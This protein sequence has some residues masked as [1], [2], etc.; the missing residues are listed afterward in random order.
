MLTSTPCPVNRSG[1]GTLP[2]QFRNFSPSMHRFGGYQAN[3]TFLID[4]LDLLQQFGA[5]A[6][7]ETH[8]REIQRRQRLVA[9]LMPRKTIRV[10]TDVWELKLTEAGYVLDSGG[11][12]FAPF[13]GAG[14]GGPPHL[15]CCRSNYLSQAHTQLTELP[16][17]PVLGPE[18]WRLS[19]KT[20][21]NSLAPA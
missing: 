5:I 10:A 2:A 16:Q 4:R 12:G 1:C 15:G 3:C 18:S 6:A 9:S 21:I 20:P 11:Y 19:L 17:E 8:Q 7:G 14:A 13:R